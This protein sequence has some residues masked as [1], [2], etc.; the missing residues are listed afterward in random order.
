M[1]TRKFILS[2]KEMPEH[3][4]NITASMANKPLPP[5]HPG[6]LQ[7]IG[8]EALAPLFP[9]ELIKQEVTSEKW[10]EIPDEVRNLY[11]I[12]RPSP[13][14]RAYE[15]EKA[16]DTP[17]KIYYKYEG[18]SP[19]GSHKPNTAVPQAYYNKQEGVKRITTETGAGQWGSALSFACQH[20][21]I[22]CEVYMVKVSYDSKPYRKLMMNTW[23]AKVHSSPTN[24]TQAGRSI[25]DM[26]PNSPGSLGIA[27][28]EAIERAAS[29][30]HTKY[31]LGSVLNHVL[32]H[33][34]IVGQEAV[35]QMEMAGDMPDIVVAPFGGGSN[36]AGL[37]FPFLRLN[38]E[39][40]KNIRCIAAEPASCPKLTRGVFRY[41]FGDTVGMTPLLPM[42]TLG[43]NFVPAP[44]HAGGLRYHGAGV[45]VSQLLK[46]KL[47]EARS[48]DQ[49]ECFQ[50]G[51]LFAKAEGIIP[52]PEAS[53]AIAT[54]IQEAIAAKISGES[55]TILFNL[56]GHGHFDMQSYEDYF[57]NKLV[58]HEVTSADIADSLSKLTTPEIA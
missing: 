33:Q 5:L 16:L 20:F 30:E 14:Y 57:A 26:D 22:E 9:M 58:K 34:T 54:V 17:A 36:F 12:W 11:A 29:D 44:I 6:T 24:H 38:L 3:W 45:I 55:K 39:E 18:V 50:A 46:D 31:A 15:L 47:I 1:K 2:E 32:L 27:I 25:L 23:G 13:L 42:Y 4:Y 28:S 10:V 7:P 21:G 37:S 52:A 51:V 49:L 41:D 48:H 56:C 35:K 43:H 40:G 8:P 53:H 19:A